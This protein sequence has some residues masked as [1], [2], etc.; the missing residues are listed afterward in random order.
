MG[1]DNS[2]VGFFG[3]ALTYFEYAR[4]FGLR[5]A[6]KYALHSWGS[7]TGTYECRVRR[8]RGSSCDGQNAKKNPHHRLELTKPVALAIAVFE[9]CGAVGKQGLGIK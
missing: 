9:S 5:G 7:S 2:G 6:A 8:E 4:A 3:A 1:S